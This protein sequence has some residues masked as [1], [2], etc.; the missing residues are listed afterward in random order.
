LTATGLFK[1]CLFDDGVFNLR[2]FIRSGASD[3]DI[4]KIFQDTILKKPENGFVA[5]KNRKSEKVSE[6]M[7]TIG[8]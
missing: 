6:S 7:S 3:D 2:D 5:E 1:N 8:G 4:K